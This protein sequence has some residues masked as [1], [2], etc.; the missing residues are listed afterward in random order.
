MDITDR[1]VDEFLSALPDA[2]R[3]DMVA[4]DDVISAAMTGLPRE[5]YV[6]KFWGGSSQEIIGYGRLSYSRADG[7]D[8]EWFMVGLAV[9]KN[10]LSLYVS[11]VE[12]G[13]YLAE[14]YGKDLGKV[15]VGKSSISF[16]S[17][18]DIDLDAVGV[19]V[20]RARIVLE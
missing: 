12:D 6:G 3:G 9:Q 20:A 10:Y 18:D 4:L 11:A 19:L 8:V 15:K 7:K 14:T 17:V 16:R 5:L 2:V 1:N 13:K